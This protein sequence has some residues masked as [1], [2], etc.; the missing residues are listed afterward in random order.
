M[1]SVMLSAL[2][3][4]PL[5]HAACGDDKT[6]DTGD[7]EPFDTFADCYDDHHNEESLPVG[8]AIVVCC[9]DHPIGGDDANVVC[10]EVAADCEDYVDANIGDDSVTATEITAACADYITQRSE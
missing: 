4:L 7:A 1:R 6:N 3:C 2:L 10:G 8:E 5:L 9:I